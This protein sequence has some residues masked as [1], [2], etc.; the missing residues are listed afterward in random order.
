MYAFR[1]KIHVLPAWTKHQKSHS[2]FFIISRQL[3]ER[4]S[5]E[6]HWVSRPLSGTAMTIGTIHID[7]TGET[8]AANF[9]WKAGSATARKTTRRETLLSVFLYYSVLPNGLLSV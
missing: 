7:R 3:I 5:V 1:K 2:I 9:D 6:M 8:P 4:Y